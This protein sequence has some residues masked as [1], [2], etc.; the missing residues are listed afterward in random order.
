MYRLEYAAIMASPLMLSILL[1]IV[2][3]IIC[4]ITRSTAGKFIDGVVFNV[5][6]D[7]LK[8]KKYDDNQ[9]V[10]YFREERLLLEGEL[11]VKVKKE[12]FRISFWLAFYIMFGFGQFYFLEYSYDCDGRPDKDCFKIGSSDNDPVDCTDPMI[13]NG[14][15]PVIC[16]RLVL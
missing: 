6:P 7:I 16:Y 12:L 5:F 13:A 10:V 1:F 11:L 4:V 3:Y 8:T 15:T 2:I 14:T 9:T